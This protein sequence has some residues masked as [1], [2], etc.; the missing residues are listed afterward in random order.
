MFDTDAATRKAIEPNDIRQGAL[1]D[2]W[3]M[4]ALAALAEFPPLITRLFET[5]EHEPSGVYRVSVCKN[6]AWRHVTLDDRFPCAG[7]DSG[8]LFSHS[9]GDELWV[10]LLEKCYA[11]LHGSYKAI[12]AGCPAEGMMDLTGAPGA[13]IGFAEEAVAAE[14]ADGAFWRKLVQWDRGGTLMACGTPG[15]D[16]MTKSRGGAQPAGGLVPGH[17]YS[18]ISC[19]E[20]ASG[21]RLLWIRNPWGSF[22]WDGAWSDADPAWTDDIKAEIEAQT[23]IAAADQVVENDGTFWMSFEDFRERFDSL[24]VCHAFTS[25]KKLLKSRA[26]PRVA[27]AAAAGSCTTPP[28]GCRR[29]STRSPSAAATRVTR[30]RRAS[31]ASS[32]STRRTRASSARPS[33]RT[34]RSTCCAPTGA[35]GTS[36]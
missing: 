13:Y 25:A 11:K 1:G 22:E 33:T 32:R 36:S 23:G 24:N 9:H 27:G 21:A 16:E 29:G 26:R 8:P 19:A 4:C 2:C 30:P 10:L 31:R 15:V 28:R 14:L 3:F 5:R 7:P 12:E 34:S 18:L 17:A 6:G 35:A 20:L